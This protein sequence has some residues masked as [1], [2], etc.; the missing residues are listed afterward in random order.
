MVVLLENPAN[1]APASFPLRRSSLPRDIPAPLFSPR[2]LQK[3]RPAQH[4]PLEIP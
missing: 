1:T 3:Q 2:F 4:I